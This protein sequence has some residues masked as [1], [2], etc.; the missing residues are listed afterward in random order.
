MISQ[1]I[2][3]RMPGTAHSL[4]ISETILGIPVPIANAEANAE[5]DARSEVKL[6]SVILKTNGYSKNR[7]INEN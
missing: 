7:R 3:F 2:P 1:T 6:F 5:A 4:K